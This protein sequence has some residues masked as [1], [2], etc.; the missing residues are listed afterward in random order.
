MQAFVVALLKKLIKEGH[1]TLVFS[2]SIVMLDL[3]QKALKRLKIRCCRID[4]SIAQP[5]KRQ[6]II[7][8][9]QDDRR[10]KVFLLTSGV[11]VR[12][13]DHIG[14]AAGVVHW[15]GQKHACLHVANLPCSRSCYAHLQLL[16]CCDH[17]DASWS[18]AIKPSSAQAGCLR[19]W[20]VSA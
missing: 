19:R 20:A 18:H 5:A 16:L 6:Q 17:V 9:F 2:Q 8:K 14:A 12:W 10:L 1:D 3:L 7:D 13:I 11:R 15:A 4:G